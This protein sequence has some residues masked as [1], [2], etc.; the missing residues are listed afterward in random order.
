MATG[1]QQTAQQKQS[2]SSP[3]FLT[4]EQSSRVVKKRESVIST[5]A[6]MRVLNIIKHWVSKHQQDFECDKELKAAVV[7]MLQ[8]MACNTMLNPAEHK[9]AL[10][11]LRTIAKDSAEQKNKVDLEK[12]LQPPEISTKENFDTLSAMDIAE[13]LTFLDHK[14]FISIRSEELLGQTW[15]K[16]EKSTKA[17]HVLLVSKRFNEVSRLVVSEVVTRTVLQ[18]RVA[19]IEKW[20]AIADI[21]R[22]MNNYNGVLQICAAFVN[23]SVYRMKKTWEKVPKSTKQTIEKLQ[24]LVSSNGRFKN[25]RDALHRCDPPCIPYLGMYLTDLSIIEEGIPGNTDEGLVNFSKMRTIAHVIREIRL[26]QQ[27]PYKIEHIP[28][29]TNYLLDAN[30]S[31]TTTKHTGLPWKSNPSSL[32][33]PTSQ[34]IRLTEQ[35]HWDFHWKKPISKGLLRGIRIP[36][37]RPIPDSFFCGCQGIP[38]IV[39]KH[40]R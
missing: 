7:D 29:V 18:E 34:S 20:A 12:L 33:C 35:Y 24:D 25:M 16:S 28:R 31:L 26:F 17:P 15:M 6:T 21:C 10:S 23:S 32:V 13:Q 1:G 4:S 11:L 39:E 27:T 5:A 9:V 36:F 40:R 14:I 38:C 37:Q 3:R 30:L 8:E 22:C 19:C 2:Q